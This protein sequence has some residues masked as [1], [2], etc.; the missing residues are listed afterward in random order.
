MTDNLELPDDKLD[1]DAA[2]AEPVPD[3][4]DV[5]SDPVD[6]PVPPGLTENDDDTTEEKP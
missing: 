5:R 4:P 6:E 1:P 3:A 2:D